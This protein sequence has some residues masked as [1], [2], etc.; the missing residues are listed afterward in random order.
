[1]KRIISAFKRIPTLT[2]ILLTAFCLLMIM[3]V[4]IG[5]DDDRGILM[6]WLAIVVLIIEITRRWRKEWQF[7][8]LSVGSVVGAIFLSFLQE[9]VVNPLV[10]KIGGAGALQSQ[11]LDIYHFI[12]KDIILLFTPMG[13]ISGIIGAITLF[14]IRLIM[15]GRKKSVSG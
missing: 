8:L 13:I 2:R 4:I 15:L 9:V 12:N 14:F 7:L 11:G 5:I 6:G 1:M 10:E 3:A